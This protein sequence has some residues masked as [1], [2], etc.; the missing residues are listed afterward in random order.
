MF[1]ARSKL[2]LDKGIS[3]QLPTVYLNFLYF[4]AAD[5]TASLEISN[6]NQE[7]GDYHSDLFQ[8]RKKVYLMAK[9]NANI[10]IE[11]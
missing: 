6:N 10:L 1:K 2:L 7:T 9:K 11:R 3:K 8:Q 5:L 4:P